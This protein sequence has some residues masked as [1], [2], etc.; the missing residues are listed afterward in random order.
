MNSWYNI[1][2]HIRQQQRISQ[3][4]YRQTRSTKYHEK[5]K[6]KTVIRRRINIDNNFH[7]EFSK[8]DYKN[9]N[10]NRSLTYVQI[11]KIQKNYLTRKIF[12]KRKINNFIINKFKIEFKF[13]NNLQSYTVRDNLWNLR[14]FTYLYMFNNKNTSAVKSTFQ[15]SIHYIYSFIVQFH[16]FYYSFQSSSS[17][18]QPL[19]TP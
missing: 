15:S 9:K 4:L 14:C 3:N 11:L 7:P 1:L 6:N 2:F 18:D 10:L 16:L 12:F 13:I 17:R 19:P 8:V 5:L